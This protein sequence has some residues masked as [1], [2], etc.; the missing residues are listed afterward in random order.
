MKETIK[1]KLI[2]LLGLESLK[3]N[4]DKYRYRFKLKTHI[5]FFSTS[6]LL[7]SIFYYPIFFMDPASIAD[8]LSVFVNMTIFFG[9]IVSP[10]IALIYIIAFISSFF[11]YKKS[12]FKI[13]KDYLLIEKEID[14]EFGSVDNAIL[15]YKELEKLD[16]DLSDENFYK[17]MNSSEFIEKK[18]GK[19]EDIREKKIDKLDERIEKLR[20]EKE[21]VYFRT[22]NRISKTIKNI[23]YK[24]KDISMDL[25]ELKERVVVGGLS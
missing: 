1:N 9:S 23:E 24:E 3:E 15:I 12:L 22:D 5:F 6:L 10:V 11:I 7:T 20:K 21:N 16:L 14:K 8:S 19:I 17:I 4:T 2:S 18:K 25:S 13:L